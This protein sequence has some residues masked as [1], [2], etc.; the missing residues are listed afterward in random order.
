[1]SPTQRPPGVAW[2]QRLAVMACLTLVGCLPGGRIHTAN[3]EDPALS[4]CSAF[5]QGRPFGVRAAFYADDARALD[6]ILI[7]AMFVQA[8]TPAPIHVLIYDYLDQRPGEAVPGPDEH[9][10]CVMWPG[11]PASPG[12]KAFD[13]GGQ[14]I[15]F[16]RVRIP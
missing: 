15:Y 16:A 14:D 13:A 9:G 6:D 11:R 5:D 2:T 7:G 1:V 12:E 10:I 8:D 3:L 4:G